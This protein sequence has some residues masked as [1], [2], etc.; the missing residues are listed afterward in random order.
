MKKLADSHVNTI[1]VVTLPKVLAIS[2]RKN[3]RGHLGESTEGYGRN[4]D[5]LE[6]SNLSHLFSYPRGNHMNTGKTN[7]WMGLLA[8]LTRRWRWYLV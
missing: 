8:R 2:Y 1:C 7:N 4:D 6:S 3:V 5:K